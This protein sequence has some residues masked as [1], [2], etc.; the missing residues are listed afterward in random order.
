MEKL[1]IHFVLIENNTTKPGH[2]TTSTSVMIN[3]F[4]S[5]PPIRGRICND[6]RL[7]SGNDGLENWGQQRRGNMAFDLVHHVFDEDSL[8][9][10]MTPPEQK[11]DAEQHVQ[12]AK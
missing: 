1:E 11:T 4:T 9:S 5:T 10:R 12:L 6:V 7:R 8:G 3:N 2:F